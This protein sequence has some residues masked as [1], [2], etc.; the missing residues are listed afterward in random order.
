[1]ALTTLD[2]E[3]SIHIAAAPD[4]VWR[5]LADPHSWTH[6]WPGCREVVTSDR[7][8]LHDGSELTLVLRLGWLTLK[9]AARVEAATPKRTLLWIGK[10][11]GI[12]DRHAFYLD[13]KPNGTFV[14]QRAT[15]CGAGVLLFRVLRL[16]KASRRMFQGN[17][18]GLKRI[19]E[20]AA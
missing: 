14:R 20:R 9:F 13:A 6:W 12:T 11:G 2:L 8:T 18:R 16:D 4:I 10:G 7:K 19:S 1:M 3:E 5:F 17:L 15:Y